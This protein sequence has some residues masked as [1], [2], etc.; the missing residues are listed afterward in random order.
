MMDEPD[1]ALLVALAE[2]E[3]LRE[4]SRTALEHGTSRF[5]FYMIVSS[6]AAAVATAVITA[7]HDLDDTATTILAT[8]GVVVLI[9]GASIFAK[10]TEYHTRLRR[11]SV[12]QNLVRTFLARR[13]PEVAPYLLLRTLDADGSPH[14]PH[15]PR[16]R[17]WIYDAASMTGVVGMINSLLTG[18]A[19]A[20]LT[21]HS[22]GA[23]W[24]V[25]ASATTALALAVSGH[26][27]YARVV[28]AAADRRI[29][30]VIAERFPATAPQPS[31]GADTGM[32]RV[33]EVQQS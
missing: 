2:Y 4:S 16:T 11:Y 20:A 5:H 28:V 1:T 7:G 3:F 17:L 32:D 8:L 12:A 26:V 31:R 21:W 23:R 18:G 27:A 6:G 22:G 19:V 10:Q 14:M 24:F 9:L 25:I 33:T 29:A 15:V 13:A 30:E